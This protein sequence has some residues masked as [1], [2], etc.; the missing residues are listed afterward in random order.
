MA[1]P[2]EKTF[3]DKIVNHLVNVN[4]F[5]LGDPK[6]YG[7]S[8]CMNLDTLCEFLEKTQPKEFKRI[9]DKYP[10]NYKQ[11]LYNV[12]EKTIQHKGLLN[13]LK[14]KVNVHGTKIKL[15]FQKPFNTLDETKWDN[16]NDN[17]FEVVR[18]FM[19]DDLVSDTIDFVISINGITILCNEIK[20]ILAGQTYEDAEQQYKKDRSTRYN[21]FKF[22]YR[23]LAY[24]AFDD[25]YA[26]V[27]P[28]LE[29]ED[30]V[31]LP[32]NQGSEG[33]GNAGG[34]GNPLTGTYIGT[35]HIWKNVFTKDNLSNL[36][37]LLIEY[38]DKEKKLI[39]PRYHQFDC[40]DQ[41]VKATVAFGLG[42]SYLINH[43]AGSG[44]SFTIGHLA[45][46]LSKIYTAKNKKF[47]D[48]VIVISDKLSLNDNLIK[49]I[50]KIDATEESVICIN[51]KMKSKDLLDAI[52]KGTAK[53]IVVN[54]QKFLYIFEELKGL[55]INV[56][57]CIDEA[58]SSQNGKCA[59]A[60]KAALS[61]DKKFEAE[62]IENA[63]ENEE[64]YINQVAEIMS[65]T[66][67]P[68]N[69]NFYAFTATYTDK[70]LE[71]FGTSVNGDDKA[72]FVP[73]HNY[74][75]RQ[76]IEEGFILDPLKHVVSIRTYFKI[77]NKTP[78]NPEVLSVITKKTLKSIVFDAP[79][80]ITENVKN[81]LD[82]I[83]NTTMKAINGKGK[84]MC[85]CTSRLEALLYYLEY[86][87]QMKARG[88]D[89]GILIAYSDTLNHEKDGVV[90]DYKEEDWN[91]DQAGNHISQSALPNEFK[92]DYYRLLVVANKYQVGF[93]EPLLH[94][95]FIHKSLN[96]A[97]AVQTYLRV[98]RIT[99]DKHDTLIIDYCND[100]EKI[101]KAFEKYYDTAELTEDVDPNSLIGLKQKLRDMLIYFDLDVNS[102][103]KIFFSEPAK[104]LSKEKKEL[105]NIKKQD[106]LQKCLNVVI[107]KFNKQLNSKQQKEFIGYMRQYVKSYEYI[108]QISR[109]TDNKLVDEYFFVKFLSILCKS[110]I[111][112][113]GKSLSENEL[114][115]RIQIEYLKIKEVF[116]GSIAIESSS[117]AVSEVKHAKQRAVLSGEG[118][119]EHLDSIIDGIND[120]YHTNFTNADKA[121]LDLLKEKI[122]EIPGLET[123]AMVNDKSR[124]LK[125]IFSEEFDKIASESYNNEQKLHE[126]IDNSFGKL[127]NDTGYY[128][129]VKQVIG[130]I[131]YE[132]FKNKNKG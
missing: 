55:N 37:F 33:A 80:V 28:K 76:A 21:A 47:F 5:R 95:M 19:F 46:N 74:S 25:Q 93:D 49:S 31:F 101:K 9:I 30:T 1:I 118:G 43:A 44:K 130:S 56:A 78:D 27:T 92:K 103:L 122:L 84:A 112:T 4:G 124:F 132:I 87:K 42:N 71:K 15:C 41:L 62:I 13:T 40:I 53:I 94:T 70:T 89:F 69:M 57:V 29:D 24:L 26:T 54:I 3:E 32:F 110:F 128:D 59:E 100:L 66:G 85:V 16:Y 39:F 58:H 8:R 65:S 81:E 20:Y 11:E 68:S 35:E 12:I 34:K 75:M 107:D 23:F 127:F 99:K 125:D 116:K 64:S 117:V 14:N 109:I 90:G 36:I 102:F 88:L 114:K 97:I 105:F 48:L 7:R 51:D 72:P 91:I 73:F 17:I 63:E 22:N 119:S 111:K 104:N 120:E 96:D 98:D 86:K 38:H 6:K 52:K 10:I 113:K 50:S 60:V 106:D 83:V 79:E 123:K 121:V 129:S 61:S 131:I 108:T 126:E 115:K 67:K 45:Y 82:I 18:Q 77:K 2:K